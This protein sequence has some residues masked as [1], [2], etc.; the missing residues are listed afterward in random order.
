MPDPPSDW[1]TSLS[2]PGEEAARRLRE[3]ASQVE[4]LGISGGNPLQAQ[5]GG[6]LAGIIG[7]HRPD[8]QKQ[9]GMDPG[10]G[11]VAG[12]VEGLIGSPASAAGTALGMLPLPG[13]GTGIRAWHGSPHD[14]DRFSME[15]IGTGEGGAAYG[16]G[17]YFAGRPETGLSYRNRLSRSTSPPID[18]A[19]RYFKPGT[20]IPTAWGTHQKVVSFTRLKNRSWDALLQDVNPETGEA[21]GQKYHAQV[22]DLQTLN[23]EF[24]RR[25]EPRWQPGHLY[26]VTLQTHPTHL[27]D[28]DAPLYQQPP[29]VIEALQSLGVKPWRPSSD[30]SRV[31]GSRGYQEVGYRLAKRSSK[32]YIPAAETSEALKGEGVHGIQYLDQLSRGKGE[33]TRNYVMFDDKL[34]DIV[35]KYGIPI[36]LFDLARRRLASQGQDPE[37]EKAYDAR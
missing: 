5:I 25:G 4:Q 3:W 36:A 2:G 35:G 26:E 8:A 37:H 24:D 1:W 19:E 16:H 31:T 13:A 7:G 18:V 14:F 30:W 28:W 34:I 32:E 22:P 12:L 33:G 9:W 17:L 11:G 15:T 27:L 6:L 10:E 29:G 23:A 21:F 20:I